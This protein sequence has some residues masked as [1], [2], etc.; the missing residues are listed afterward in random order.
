MWTTIVEVIWGALRAFVNKL[1]LE[2]AKKLG[3]SVSVAVFE[4]I[5]TMRGRK[6]GQE[7]MKEIE[8]SITRLQARL[9]DTQGQAEK[10]IE[11]IAFWVAVF[12]TWC[13]VLTV[14]IV[15]LSVKCWH[16]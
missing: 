4:G 5:T 1:G 8:S 16:H 10:A 14:W 15:V 3:V 12:L 11:R 6:T 7:Q 13:L 9:A 2:F